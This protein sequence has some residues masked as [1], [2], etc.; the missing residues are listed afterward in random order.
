MFLVFDEKKSNVSNIDFYL[1]GTSFGAFYCY[2]NDTYLTFVL[3]SF[4][5]VHAQYFFYFLKCHTFCR[6][7]G[8][9]MDKANVFKVDFYLLGT[10]LRAVYCYWVRPK[11][12]SITIGVDG[13][14]ST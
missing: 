4:L 10:S 5:F 6:F 1:L 14:I 3:V 7:F 12:C 13:C 11:Y 9:W 2:L 8:F